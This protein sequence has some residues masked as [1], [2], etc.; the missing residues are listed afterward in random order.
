MVTIYEAKKNEG[1]VGC[2]GKFAAQMSRPY[3]TTDC[4]FV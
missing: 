4:N 3:K 2:D 1:E